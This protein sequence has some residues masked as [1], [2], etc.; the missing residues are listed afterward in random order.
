MALKLKFL[1]SY[2][3]MTTGAKF[4]PLAQKMLQSLRIIQGLRANTAGLTPQ[5][6]P[7]GT[8]RVDA[9]RIAAIQQI[10]P[11]T[12]IKQPRRFIP[13]SGYV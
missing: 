3:K 1:W 6:S 13:T 9:D 2:E 8:I 7:Y 10:K 5:T 12:T 4:R 11:P